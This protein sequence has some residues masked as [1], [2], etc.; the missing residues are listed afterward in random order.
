MQF[1]LLLAMFFALLVSIF[2]VQNSGTVTVRL[3]WWQFGEISLVLVILGS[4]VIGALFV[5]L[6][7]VVNMIQR[8]RQIRTLQEENRHLASELDRLSPP[9]GTAEQVKPV[10]VDKSSD[11]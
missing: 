11:H 2:A 10:E 7:S 5:F 6:L 9:P 4:A 3:L 8:R 1:Y